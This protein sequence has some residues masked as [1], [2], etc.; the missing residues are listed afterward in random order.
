MRTILFCLALSTSY[1]AAA[2]EYPFKVSCSVD[3][4]ITGGAAGAYFLSRLIPVDTEKQSGREF[5]IFDQDTRQ[6]FSLSAAHL[7]DALL[8]TSVIFPPI[9]FLKRGGL[10]EDTAKSFILLTEA[11]TVSLALNNITKY[12]VQRPRPYTYIR[13]EEVE[14]FEREHAE[15]SRLSFYSGHSATVF[16]MATAGGFM[17]AAQ[18]DDLSARAVVWGVGTALATTTAG[19]RVKAGRHYPTDVIAGAIAGTAVGISV[20]WLHLKDGHDAPKLSK[21]EIGAILGGLGI[22]IVAGWV[23]PYKQDYETK[24]QAQNGSGKSLSIFPIPVGAAFRF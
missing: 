11:L 17:Y 21:R 7:S 9:A 23:L 1:P 15:D 20:P 14:A 22:G 16:T 10:E 8:A 2:E 3:G 4:T 12:A 18:S 13:A 5:F 24:G 19:L 6:N